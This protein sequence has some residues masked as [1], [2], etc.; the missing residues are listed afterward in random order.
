[1]KGWVG[2]VLLTLLVT[3]LG[4]ELGLRILHRAF[5]GTPVL[6]LVPAYRET[7]F[8]L[9]PFLV[10]GPRVS[11]EIPDKEIPE[12]ARFN[13]Q[14]FRLDGPVPERA[15]G[16]FRIVALGG[17]T[18]ENVWNDAGIHWPLVTQCILR[19]QGYPV[20][21]LNGAMS[22]F[23]TAHSL[24]R[25]QFDALE[26]DP[27][28]VVIMHAVND[29]TVNYVAAARG[30]QVDPNYRVKY[31]TRSFTGEIGTDD[32]VISRLA[33]MVR[34]RMARGSDGLVP[35]EEW[36]YDIE[37]GARIFE[38]NL[39][40]IGLVAGGAAAPAVLVTMPYSRDPANY[41]PILEGELR[42]GPGVGLIPEP[43]RF[44]ED[45]DRY[46]EGARNV[47]LTDGLGLVDMAALYHEEE[48]DFVD[49]VHYSTRGVLKFGRTA[50]AAFASILPLSA[51]DGPAPRLPE[52]TLMEEGLRRIPGALD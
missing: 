45:M 14:G 24:V 38:R 30:M 25:L 6:T 48:G 32:V 50:A 12:L 3:L 21:F 29:L 26:Y 49:P 42:V 13:E 36:S 20:R 44:A 15:E 51:T 4:L 43:D 41:A 46:N 11:W 40:M 10:F 8:A 18:T 17:S 19:D 16:E 9:S 7:R 1:M 35:R 47:A 37:E 34:Q 5:H 31:G 39:G 28:M 27:D 33:R 23:S 52:C 2:A 22:A